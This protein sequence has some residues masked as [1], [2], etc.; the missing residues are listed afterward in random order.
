VKYNSSGSQQWAQIFNDT[1]DGNDEGK[2]I[3]LDPSANVYV[4]GYDSTAINSTDY[5]TIRYN[6]S[7]TEQWNIRADGEAHMKDKATNIAIDQAGDIIVSGESQKADGTYQYKTIKYVQKQVVVPTDFDDENALSSFSYFENKGQLL[8]TDSAEID[9]VRYYTTT[10]YPQYYFMDDTISMVFAKVDTVDATMDTLHRI[11]MQFRN[12]NSTPKVYAMEEEDQYLNYFLP[13]C[14]DGITEVFGNK[15]LLY[16]NV[17]TNIDLVF[18]SNQNG[19]KYYYIVKPGATPSS[20]KLQFDGA[21]S[22]SLDGSTNVLTLNSSIGSTSFDKPIAYQLDSSNDT[23][24]ISGWSPSWQTDGA[25]NKYKFSSGPYDSTKVLVIEVDQGNSAS[26]SASIDNLEWSTYFGGTASIEFGDI[27]YDG[28]GQFYVTGHAIGSGFP[29]VLGFQTFSGGGIGSDFIIL[30]FLD[31]GFPQWT[32]YYGGNGD[33]VG[34]A[35]G[36][37]LNNDVY[38]VGYVGPNF[39]VQEANLSSSVDFFQGMHGG[40]QDIGIVK[41]SSNGNS[42]MWATYYG[43]VGY[44]N[45]L[46][47]TFD[48][49]NNLYIG[50][51][52]DGT[53]TLSLYSQ[54]G[55]INNSTGNGLILKFN[56]DATPLWITKWGGTATTATARTICVNAGGQVF[57]GG[58]VSSGTGFDILNAGANSTYGGGAFDGWVAK[59]DNHFANNALTWSTFIGGTGSDNIKSIDVNSAGELYALGTSNS[60]GSSFP[61][62]DPIGSDDYFQGANGGSNDITLSKLSATGTLLWSTYYGGSSDERAG[63]VAIDDYGNVYT[64]ISTLGDFAPI[65]TPNLT[66]GFYQPYDND[67]DVILLAF[68]PTLDDIWGTYFGGSSYE[69]GAALDNFQNEKLLI[70]GLTSGMSS[71]FP[72]VNF[73]GAWNENTITTPNG[74]IAGFDLSPVLVLATQ[75]NE[76]TSN[77]QIFPNPVLDI[78]R[79]VVNSETIQSMEYSVVDILGKTLKSEKVLVNRGK[80]VIELN[81]NSYTSGMYFVNFKTQNTSSSVKIIKQ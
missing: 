15:R 33:D 50:G 6:S 68:D 45:A 37:D 72:I 22:V 41:L 11:N 19:I 46:D 76:L 14:S 2:A 49:Y 47:I 39:P 35:I 69:K 13:Q 67:G 74:Y 21:S 81:L 65:P 79:I 43:G 31:S 44:E 5:Y 51:E 25:S 38:V 53:S 3:V 16:S 78:A 26:S 24:H 12:T 42:C 63:E 27:K 52:N 8:D 56:I 48:K 17:Y 54:T 55:A 18:Y 20:I 40:N 80:T 32:T 10:T 60:S 71:S 36:T 9:R 57:V 62:L 4:T 61:L 64:L 23:L 29:T 58:A 73:P 7:G 70:C 1:L 66:N 77:I 59:F 34:N 30:K 75:E 28:S